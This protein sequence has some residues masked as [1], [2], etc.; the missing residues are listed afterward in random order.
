MLAHGGHLIVGFCSSTVGSLPYSIK[1]IEAT[2][3]V[4]WRYKTKSELNLNLA[5]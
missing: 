3:V 5:R 4:N 2:A 1:L